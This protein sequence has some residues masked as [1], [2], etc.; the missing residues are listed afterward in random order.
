MPINVKQGSLLKGYN[1]DE[2]IVLD[3]ADRGTGIPLNR[4]IPF[5]QDDDIVILP[6]FINK[7]VN[8]LKIIGAWQLK[9]YSHS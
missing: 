1:A 2:K 5:D 3:N 8:C 4:Q 6:D 9:E 7:K